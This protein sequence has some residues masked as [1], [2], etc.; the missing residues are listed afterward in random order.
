MRMWSGNGSPFL[1][2]AF[3]IVRNFT[4]RNKRPPLPGRSWTKNTG[5]PN[6][7]LTRTANKAINQAKSIKNKMLTTTSKARFS[8]P[9]GFL[10]L[11]MRL[12]EY[13][14]ASDGRDK[15]DRK[16]PWYHGKSSMKLR[17]WSLGFGILLLTAS[18]S[19]Q[20]VTI[21]AG[22]YASLNEAVAACANAN[23]CVVNVPPGTYDLAATVVMRNGV[24]IQGQDGTVVNA[25]NVP[26]GIAFQGAGSASVMTTVSNPFADNK[27]HLAVHSTDGLAVGDMIEVG[28]GLDTHVNEITA[29]TSSEIINLRYPAPFFV[30]TGQIVKK[31]TPLHA[32]SLLSLT[33][34][35]SSNPFHFDYSRDLQIEGL[36]IENNTLYSVFYRSMRG[37]IKNSSVNA[38]L[39]GFFI[40]SS[41]DAMMA[42]NKVKDHRLAAFF[43]RGS[44]HVQVF[45]NSA[46]SNHV[47]AVANQ[48]GDSY[49]VV[50]SQWVNV[51]DNT[52]QSAS[53]YGLWADQVQDS[54]F[55]SNTVENSFTLGFYLTNSQRCVMQHN[56]AR[57]ILN[58]HGFGVSNGGNHVVTNNT[59]LNNVYGYVLLGTNKVIYGRNIALGC[60][61][62]EFL[63]QNTELIP[64]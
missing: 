30:E 39:G 1:S 60:Q 36:T 31:V 61:L 34:V 44:T 28:S 26:N 54:S 50:K 23:S 53:C 6:W 63:H 56:T 10:P 58:A 59:S 41:T 2:V 19:A 16:K 20:T 45:G 27:Y 17:F 12:Q 33:I 51:N 24:T 57:N 11:T 62:D 25:Q 7:I 32:A 40:S 5:V 35:N 64:R 38:S 52:S 4:R 18:S 37:R 49:T 13:L 3:L 48:S 14:I 42:N 9:S 22:D 55:T 47:Y 21:N 46:E 15:G 29:I 8:A 43:V